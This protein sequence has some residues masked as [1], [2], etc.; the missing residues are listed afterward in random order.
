MWRVKR[1]EEELR[2]IIETIE[3]KPRDPRSLRCDICCDFKVGIDSYYADLALIPWVGA[4]CMIFEK[5]GNEISW[6]SLYCRRD[7]PF[8]EDSLINCIIEFIRKKY[9][10]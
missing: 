2:K 5:I 8:K 9:V 4:E 10:D 7:I 6:N 1:T 3:V